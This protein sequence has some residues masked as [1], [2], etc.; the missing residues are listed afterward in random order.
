MSHMSHAGMY[1]TEREAAAAWDQSAL[2]F[3]GST[4]GLQ[5]NLPHLLTSYDLA[6][7]GSPWM[8]ACTLFWGACM[9]GWMGA[10]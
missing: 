8:G 10:A 3:R 9:H 1:D 2:T 5:L 6:V 4:P 7:R